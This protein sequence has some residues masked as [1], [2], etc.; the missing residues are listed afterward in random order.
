M[1][2]RLMESLDHLFCHHHWI[3]ERRENGRLGL[4]CM[5]CLQRKE[6]NL[7]KLIE[8]QIDYEPIC[9]AYP[10]QLP[11]PLPWALDAQRHL[12]KKPKKAA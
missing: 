9:P 1:F 7:L 2:S 8:W 3:R 11:P 5:H 6:H 12:K 4:R 10:S